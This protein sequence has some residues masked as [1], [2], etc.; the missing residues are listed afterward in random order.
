MSLKENLMLLPNAQVIANHYLLCKPDMN[1]YF[2]YGIRL[3]LLRV[4]GDLLMREVVVI[5]SLFSCTLAV[6]ILLLMLEQVLPLAPSLRAGEDIVWES[7][8][9][10]TVATWLLTLGFVV[11]STLLLRAGGVVRE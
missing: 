7:T 1:D 8:R 6:S 2:I 10:T 4:C 5:C 11:A 3:F 9:A